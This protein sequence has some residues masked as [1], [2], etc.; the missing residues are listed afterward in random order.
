V[1]KNLPGGFVLLTATAGQMRAPRS[2]LKLQGFRKVPPVAL[3]FPRHVTKLSIRQ[4]KEKKRSQVMAQ[5]AEELLL[6]YDES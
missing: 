3:G 1:T 6:Q 2:K 5:T 4:T